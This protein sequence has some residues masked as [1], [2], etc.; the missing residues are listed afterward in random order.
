MIQPTQTIFEDTTQYKKAMTNDAYMKRCM[1]VMDWNSQW[2]YC[3]EMSKFIRKLST[4][5]PQMESKP[6]HRIHSSA[7]VYFRRYYLNEEI[8][9]SKKDP[10]LIAATSVF[11]SSKVEG[12]MIP[13]KYII[14]KAKK[15]MEFPFVQDDIISMERELVIK[16]KDSLIVW[17]PLKEYELINQ[18][19]TFPPFFEENFIAILNDAYLTNTILMYKPNEITMGCIVTAGILQNCDIRSIVSS[20]KVNLNNVYDVANEML[21]FYMFINSEKYKQEYDRLKLKFKFVQE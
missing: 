9:K 21:E 14:E 2:T 1:K 8:K 4:C 20:S 10:R 12:I 17:H 11:F 3:I 7:I 13:T 5:H 19:Y 16:L 15:L 6:A 18:Q